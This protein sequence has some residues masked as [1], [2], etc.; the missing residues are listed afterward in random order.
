MATTP[1]TVKQLQAV[2]QLAP[3]TGTNQ[4]NTF[5]GTSSNTLTVSSFGSPPSGGLRMSVRI[6]N[7]GAPADGRAQVKIWG[8][9]PSIMNQLSTLGLV[10]NLVPKNTITISAGDANGMSTVFTGT[11]W[12]AYA[13]YSAMPD[14]PFVFECLIGAADA[15]LSVPPTSY[16][17]AAQVADIAAGIARQMNIGFQNFAV[18]G[19]LRNVYLRGSAKQQMDTLARH[20]GFTWGYINGG[21]TVGI[22]PLGTSTTQTAATA[23]VVSPSTGQILYPAFT[24][25][26]IIVYSLFNP[27]IAFGGLIQ[28]DS[29]LLQGIAQAQGAKGSPFPSRWAVNKLDL[30][31]DALVPKGQWMAT[32]YAY[33]PG[34]AKSIMPPAT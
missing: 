21:S 13:D 1:F 27:Q 28:V 4:P 9:P 34:A 31:L 2:V 29:S 3:N 32:I 8:L 17:S 15:V 24:Q 10:F 5:A 25:Q 6:Q 20:A 18:A 30:A 12:Q 7:S 26:G 14:V 11:I 23:P 33:N 19:T 16:A 22:W